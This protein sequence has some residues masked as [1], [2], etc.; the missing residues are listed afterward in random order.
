M[1][2]SNAL[3]VRQTSGMARQIERRQ[4]PVQTVLQPSPGFQFSRCSQRKPVRIKS[5]EQ[6]AL[7]ALQRTRSLR[8]VR[9]TQRIHTLRG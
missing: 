9:R 7:Q 4:A 2:T 3:R 8:Q 1:T 5:I 6:Q